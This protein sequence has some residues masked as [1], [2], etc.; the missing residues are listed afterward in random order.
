M[1]MTSAVYLQKL[2][3]IFN[4][5]ELLYTYLPPYYIQNGSNMLFIKPNIRFYEYQTIDDWK[6]LSKEDY[7]AKFVQ[8]FQELQ[9]WYV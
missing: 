5:K 6:F 3:Q 2:Y 1:D 9:H 8:C 7:I 4:S